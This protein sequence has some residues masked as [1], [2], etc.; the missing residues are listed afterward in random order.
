MKPDKKTITNRLV[1]KLVIAF[2]LL[3]I[4]MGSSYVF[5]AVY[6][7]NKYAEETT[8]KLNASLANELIEEKFQN[9][10]PF[11]DSGE[12]NKA[13]FGD[14][15]HDMMA[16]NRSIEVYLV[17]KTG[18]VLYSVVLDHSN[19]NEPASRIDLEPVEQFILDNG[20]NYI[21]GDD[22]RN[23]GEKKIFSAAEF[24]V[25]GRQ[26]YI[27]IV[28]TGKAWEEVTSSLFTSY[29]L[30]LGTG[31]TALAM[32][33]AFL[34]GGISIW[35][36]TKNLREVINTVRRFREGDHQ[37]RVK[38]PERSDLSVL[39]ETFNEM[40]DTISRNIDEMRS[41]DDLRRELIANVSH[42]LRTPLSVLQGY[43]ETLQMK[44]GELND[45]Q[46]EE[47]LER[48]HRSSEKLS[49]LVSQLFEYSKLEAE[50][51]KPKKEPFS[52]LDLSYDL[53]SN[54]KMLASEKKI[55][56]E[57][58]SDKDIPLV[59][60]DISL[61][62]RA[63]Q[64]LMDNA[65][66]YTPEGGHI[67]LSLKAKKSNVSVMITDSGPGIKPE[68]QVAMFERYRTAEN[69]GRK[70]STGLGL[71]IVKKIMELHNTTIELINT[72]EQGACFSFSLPSYNV[73][74]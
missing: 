16:V 71:A 67:K 5:I 7:T 59:F 10:S 33:F 15:M 65:I 1:V 37:I 72:P 40:A 73:A 68:D 60:A 12:V 53:V 44:E 4:L 64:N 22:P 55:D 25:D 36:L 45:K 14:L 8:Q 9:A 3:V 24:E 20:E 6:F 58:I 57:V 41:V 11:L 56:I 62:E 47:Y 13:L 42:D 49:R 18:D 38:N 35:F 61:V 43:V 31:A 17:S 63:I 48:I 29:F 27:Y 32:I 50:Q 21:L 26:G 69:S 66:K 46:R 74:I 54:Y 19:P 39:A 30:R 2:L 23:P 34:I 28:L 51:V 52:I 70:D